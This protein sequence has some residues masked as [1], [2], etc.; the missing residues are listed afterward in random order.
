M[1]STRR[2]L[3][4]ASLAVPLAM[5][6][7]RAARAARTITFAAYSGAFQENYEAC[8]VGPFRRA[9]PDIGVSYYPFANSTQGLALLESR[10]QSAGV[11]VCML[12]SAVAKIATEE[13][14][15]DPIPPNSLPVLAELAPQA[16]IP[17]VAG[18][19]VTF[20][21]LALLYA[22]SQ[23]K[24]APSSWKALWDT[25]F[26]HR[27][28]IPAPPD[29]S[30]VALTLIANAIFGDGDYQRSIDAGITAI[31]GMAPRVR[32]W[33][34]RPDIY[35]YLIEGNAILGPGWN[36]QGQ[37]HAQ[38]SG[39]RLAATVPPEG[40]VYQANTVNLVKGSRDPE[41][42]RLFLAYVLGAE[43]QKAVA[44]R[45]YYGPVNPAARVS[46]AALA[47]TGATPDALAGMIPVDWSAIARMQEFIVNQWRRR[48]LP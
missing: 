4:V 27:I 13:G 41:A 31:G 28:A 10:R 22:P 23:V 15:L 42:A 9:H 20:N 3:L 48:I 44:E 38:D 25:A 1:F 5:P 40:S 32:S 45:M 17:G 36:A 26:D 8:V 39:G 35:G 33:D 24:P 11:D 14:L 47:R 30:G 12:D 21:P 6:L 29:R 34:P 37:L 7:V 46:P 18:P 43:A 16:F 2:R 19:V